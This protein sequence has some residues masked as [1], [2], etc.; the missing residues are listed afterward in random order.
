MST[1][2]ILWINTLVIFVYMTAL[3]AVSLVLK[4]AGIGRSFWG[5][6]FVVSVVVYFIFS[7]GYTLRKIL[8]LVL[9]AI[10]GLRLSFYVFSQNYGRPEDPWYQAMRARWGAAFWWTGYFQVFFTQGVLMLVV[11]VCLVAAQNGTAADRVTAWDIV[12]LLVWLI[13][14]FLVFMDDRRLTR[15]KHF[16]HN[17]E[18]MTDGGLRRYLRYPNY[19]GEAV[20]WWGYFLIAV[21]AGGW[22]SFFSPI[23]MTLLMLRTSGVISLK[24]RRAAPYDA[25]KDSVS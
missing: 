14:F 11:S 10:W 12:G 21:A 24:K 22:W 15:F 25:A 6:G 17:R 19:L 3:W 16:D 18:Q 20:I 23:L 2:Q 5:L 1:L 13:G 4:D 9:V 7:Q 8:L